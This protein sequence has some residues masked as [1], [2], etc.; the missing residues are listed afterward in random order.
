M[1]AMRIT[2]FFRLGAPPPLAVPSVAGACSSGKASDPFAVVGEPPSMS[3]VVE[4]I[5]FGC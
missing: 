3:F 1:A 2:F 4:F 5:V